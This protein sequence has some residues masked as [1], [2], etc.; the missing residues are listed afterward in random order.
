M[1]LKPNIS[2]IA[3]CLA[4]SR[5]WLPNNG[6]KGAGRPLLPSPCTTPSSCRPQGMTSTIHVPTSSVIM[7][8]IIDRCF[9]YLIHHG[10]I[11]YAP[12]LRYLVLFPQQVIQVL[13]TSFWK[14]LSVCL[15]YRDPFLIFYWPPFGCLSRHNQ[16]RYPTRLGTKEPQGNGRYYLRPNNTLNYTYPGAVG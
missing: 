2:V 5:P 6:G 7:H 14:N 4:L 16:T 9:M 3:L 15:I 13:R 12:Y 11:H 8:I 1:E 10:F